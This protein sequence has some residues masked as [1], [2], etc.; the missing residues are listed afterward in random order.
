MKRFL[1]ILTLLLVAAVRILHADPPSP[2]DIARLVRDLSAP[3]LAAR[4]RA[5]RQLLEAGPAVLP[6]LPPPDLVATPGARESLKRL[7]VQLERRRARESASPSLVHWTEPLTLPALARHLAEQSKNELRLAP[8]TPGETTIPPRPDPT[9]F[10]QALDELC[11][12]H[13]LRWR[14]SDEG[15]RLLLEPRPA[16]TAA[17]EQR[18]AYQGPFRL[19]TGSPE[20]R[21]IVGGSGELLR[22][23][24]TVSAE[25]RVRPLFLF[26]AASDLE[27]T[28]G[29]EPPLTAWN[30]AARYELPLTVAGRETSTTLDFRLDDG[31][32][33]GT[34]E[35]KL[36]MTTAL[37]VERIPFEPGSQT[38]GT[39]RRR[40]GTSVTVR[41]WTEATDGTSRSLAV[42]LAVSYDT[43]GPA[44]ESHRTWVWH[45]AAYLE[46]ADG[47]RFAYQDFSATQAADGA[48]GVRYEF[49]SLPADGPLTLV[50]EA[51]TL[52]LDLPI[53]LKLPLEAPNAS[54]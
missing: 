20:R 3:E 45:N 10:W 16:G 11:E 48:V 12:A 30:P 32:P 54:S 13:D 33:A 47:T 8:E 17:P 15:S 14:W 53:E 37:A 42:E 46:A 35:G 19:A 29:K 1:S 18:I 34:L 4:V 38:V 21:P 26:F 27:I 25:P 31:P 6:L 50:Y 9:P 44:F 52:L 22:L 2:T 24:L 5:E 40:G 51:P 41:E 23:P 43:G 7:R 36:T 39:V 49:P 28:R